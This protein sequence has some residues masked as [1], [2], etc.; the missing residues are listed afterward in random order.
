MPYRN[1]TSGNSQ[2]ITMYVFATAVPLDASKTVASITLPNVAA[3]VDSNTAA[4]HVIA[5][6][7]A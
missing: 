1:S 6:G 5:V 7:E 4:M 3:Q 2:A